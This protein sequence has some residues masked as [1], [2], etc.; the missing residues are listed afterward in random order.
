[1]EDENLKKLCSV[2]Q[3]Q[4][5]FLQQERDALLLVVQKNEL[6]AEYLAI[7]NQIRVDRNKK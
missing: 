2:L 4:K 3:L 6:Y 5:E 1:M 7:F